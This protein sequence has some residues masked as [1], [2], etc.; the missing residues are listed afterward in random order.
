MT[1]TTGSSGSHRE[2]REYD[3]GMARTFAAVVAIAIALSI[4]TWF[5]RS[6]RQN[7]HCTQDTSFAIATF[8]MKPHPEESAE[9][10][11]PLIY[12]SGFS[13]PLRVYFAGSLLTLLFAPAAGGLAVLWKPRHFRRWKIAVIAIVVMAI[14]N[15]L[16]PT[17]IAGERMKALLVIGIFISILP[18]IFL[19]LTLGDVTAARAKMKTA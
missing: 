17:V 19:R 1:T 11:V 12:Q 13:V 14:V 2:A 3:M 9:G 4:G 15:A 6:F 16:I 18:L 8:D 5:V 7:L 10:P